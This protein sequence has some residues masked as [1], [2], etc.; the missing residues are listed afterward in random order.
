MEKARSYV[1]KL[2]TQIAAAKI[3]RHPWSGVTPIETLEG[4]VVIKR[5][6]NA[7]EMTH[8]YDLENAKE[9]VKL[10]EEFKR[11]ENLFSDEEAKTSFPTKKRKPS[12]Q[13]EEKA[14]TK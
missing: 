10:P 9:E 2:K 6:H 14:I 5:A 1:Q 12:P 13:Y 3:E 8:K 11:H 7:I 4:P